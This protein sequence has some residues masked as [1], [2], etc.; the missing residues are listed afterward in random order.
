MISE[1]FNSYRFR[2]QLGR[3]PFVLSLVTLAI[4]LKLTYYALLSAY[5]HEAVYG[6]TNS[7][8]YLIAAYG[9]NVLLALALLPLCVARL[10]NIGWSPYWAIFILLSLLVSPWHMI[11]AALNDAGI[12]STSYYFSGFNMIGSIVLLWFVFVLA[13]HKGANRNET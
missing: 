1:I 4:G 6:S 7:E 10:R 11:I 9:V 8:K 13:F 5:A 2:S 3:L 12:I